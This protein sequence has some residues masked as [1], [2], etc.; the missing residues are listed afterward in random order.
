M[1]LY[2][3]TAEYLALPPAQQAAYDRA[4]LD[5]WTVGRPA[6]W[7]N[8]LIDENNRKDAAEER[9]NQFLGCG[10]PTDQQ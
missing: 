8:A 3:T 4:L 7:A 5:Y 2:I 9:D 10:L 6:F 1:K